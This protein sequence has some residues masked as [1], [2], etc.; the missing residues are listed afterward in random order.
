[1]SRYLLLLH[2]SPAG[3]APLSPEEM[4]AVIAEYTAWRD[5]LESEGRLLGSHKLTD[6]GG[7]SMVRV[8][9]EIRVTDGPYTEAKEVVGG[10]FLIEAE[11]YDDAVRISR[12]C[13]H[14]SYGGRIEVRQVDLH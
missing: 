8:D 12:D 10:Y 9:G 13:P 7:K 3:F 1:M 2:E 14:L 4:Q 5:R 11:D 6:E